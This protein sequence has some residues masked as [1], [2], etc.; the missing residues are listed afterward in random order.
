[1]AGG[2]GFGRAEFRFEKAGRWI[3]LGWKIYSLKMFEKTYK[4][5][6]A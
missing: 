6:Q 5:E 3:G 2:A 4:E 1:L